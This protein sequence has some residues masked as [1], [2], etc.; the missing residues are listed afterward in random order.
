MRFDNLFSL[1]DIWERRSDLQGISINITSIPGRPYQIKVE[2][3]VVDNTTFTG[4]YAE[5]WATL[6]KN[7]N[8]TSYL[9]KPED[10]QWGIIQENGEWN[11]MICKNF[12]VSICQISN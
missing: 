9:R 2:D 3:G 11:G 6:E 5:I 7:C 10:G 8:F 4:L 1:Q 12:E